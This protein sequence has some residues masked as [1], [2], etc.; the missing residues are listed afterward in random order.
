MTSNQLLFSFLRRYPLLAVL[1]VLLGFSGALFNGVG[2]ALIVPVLLDFLGQPLELAALPPIVQALLNPFYELDPPYRV[3]AMASVVVLLLVLKNLMVYAGSLVANLLSRRLARDMREDG[4]RMVLNVDMDFH[5]KMRV[6]D[7]VNRLGGECARAA[8]AVSITL[9]ILETSITIL[10]FLL[11]LVAMSWKLTIASSLL[12]LV[13][14]WVNQQLVVRSKS[15]GKELSAASRGYSVR[16]L[17]LLNG[18]RLVRSVGSEER[19][20]RQIVDRVRQFEHVSFQSQMNFAAISPLS[21]VTG[22]LALIGIV[23]MGRL[24]FAEELAN[25]SAILLTYLFFLFRM[26]PFLAQLNNARSQFANTAASVEVVHDFLRRDTKPFMSN[27]TRLYAGLRDRLEIQHLSFAYPGHTEPVLQDVSLTVPKGTTLALVGSSGAGKSTLADLLP[28][29]YDPTDGAILLDGQDLRDFDMASYRRRLGIV[30]QETFLFNDTIRNNIAYARPEASDDEIVQAANQ[31]HALEFI[32]KLPH[33]FETEIGDRGVML[34]GGQRQRLAIARA[35]LQNPDLLILD[36]ATSAL[37]TVSE[38]IVQAAL[39]DLSRD[40]TTVV[41]AHR[42]ST[43]KNADQ[44]AVLERGQVVELGTHAE[45]LAQAGLYS[46]LCKM[47]DSGSRLDIQQLI[48][49]DLLTQLS[50]EARTYLTATL[51]ALQ[52]QADQ[53][54][55]NSEED[56]QLVHD[57]YQSAANLLRLI[58]LLEQ[59]QLQSTPAPYGVR[60]AQLTAAALQTRNEAIE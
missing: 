42:L 25:L 43:I 29:F 22:V 26:L 38:R 12:L 14:A 11:F 36:E 59:N 35:L 40:R 28:R 56:L 2:T 49:R 6:G 5:A 58:E 46:K 15:F 7:I 19:E 39:D 17:E 27:G 51:G 57:A 44:I 21:E 54:A 23:V 37:D 53:I 50:F 60:Q 33:G 10:V 47:Q 32:E 31:A 1:K 41:I 16:L 3:L 4:L 30:S 52:L 13:V 48:Q 20:Y 8:N 34:S 9:R 45:L 18:M 55:V 24:L